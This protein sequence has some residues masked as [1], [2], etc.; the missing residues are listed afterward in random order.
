ML[1]CGLCWKGCAMGKYTTVQ[2][3]EVE[4]LKVLYAPLLD[5]APT[6]NEYKKLEI[7]LETQ[8]LAVYDLTPKE[9]TAKR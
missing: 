1:T 5:A 6:F 4:Q 9:R 2:E 3:D 7:S 8:I